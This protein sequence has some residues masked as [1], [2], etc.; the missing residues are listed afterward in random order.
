VDV[1]FVNFGVMQNLL[2]GLERAVEEILAKLFKMGMG[3]RSV[4]VDTLEER[5]DLD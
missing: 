2:D 4:E 5:V 1:R 3:E